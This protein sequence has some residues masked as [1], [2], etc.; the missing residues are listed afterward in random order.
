MYEKVENKRYFSNK[1]SFLNAFATILIVCLHSSSPERFG[2]PLSIRSFTP[3]YIISCLCQAAVPMFFFLSAMLFYKGCDY[4]T[5]KRKLLSRVKSLVVPYIL[6]N[7]I[8][9]GIY[10]ILSHSPGISST[11]NNEYNLNS[12]RAFISAVLY[13][14]CSDLWFV[15]NL[16]IYSLLSPILLITLKNKW[17]SLC[18][19]IF[20][21]LLK[22][23]YPVGYESVYKWFT[24][25][26]FGAIWG[27]WYQVQG[28]SPLELGKKSIRIILATICLI[29]ILFILVASFFSSTAMELFRVVSPILI[30]TIIDIVGYKYIA[31]IFRQRTWMKF[32]F[33]IYCCHHLVIN[34]LQ[35][36]VV[37]SLPSTPQVVYLTYLLSPMVTISIIVAVARVLSRFPLFKP[38]SGWRS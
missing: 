17:A 20:S 37:I 12:V 29:G 7:T 4:S 13:S 38:L 27:H 34:I 32:T 19:L 22:F 31:N 35:K 8:L 28:Y 24:I 23:C 36:L 2:F 1:V 30:W 16:I 26:Y 10:Y 6:W 25:Y 9:V 14:R 11:L 15:K 5:I 33:V 21:L 18:V 3:I